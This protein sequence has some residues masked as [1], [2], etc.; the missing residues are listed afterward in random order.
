[1]LHSKPRSKR[2]QVSNY[3]E[4]INTRVCVPSLE[5][6]ALLNSTSNIPNMVGAVALCDRDAKLAITP[7]LI[8]D[9]GAMSDGD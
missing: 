8:G 3:D 7:F 4:F 6:D 1:V 2:S 5:A 9:F